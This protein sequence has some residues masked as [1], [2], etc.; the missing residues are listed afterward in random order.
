MTKQE[1][2]S[3][4]EIVL[5]N[6]LLSLGGY[7]IYQNGYHIKHFK[8]K[9][10]IFSNGSSFDLNQVCNFSKEDAQIAIEEYFKGVF[11]QFIS[12]MKECIFQY[13]KS[14]NQKTELYEDPRFRIARILR[15]AVAHNSII[16]LDKHDIQALPIEFCHVVYNS[17]MHG[18]PLTFDMISPESAI[19]LHQELSKV[20]ETKLQ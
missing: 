20:V 15:N 16:E 13:A 12:E 10:L 4:L 7:F 9:H 1:L 18:Q 14:S 3:Q 11:R 5:N 2:L 17:S 19:S 6:Y 8:D